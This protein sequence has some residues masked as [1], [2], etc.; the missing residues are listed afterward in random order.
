VK[1]HQAINGVDGVVS[2]ITM[3]ELIVKPLELGRT[4]LAEK[5][6]NALR[7]LPNVTLCDCTWKTGTLAGSLRAKYQMAL[8]DMFQVACA[9]EHGKVLVSNDKA[10]RKVTEIDV[11][12]LSELN[13]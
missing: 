4:D 7:N 5:Y 12:L 8:P 1:I 11:V 3:A 10:L 9:M 13:K 2:P 6:R